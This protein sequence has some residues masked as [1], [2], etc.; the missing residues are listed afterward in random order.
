MTM[1]SQIL[2]RDKGIIEN[3]KIGVNPIENVNSI[4]QKY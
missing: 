1:I 4:Q 3:I 2:L